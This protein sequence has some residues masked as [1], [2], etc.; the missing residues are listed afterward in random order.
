MAQIDGQSGLLDL[1]LIKHTTI[2]QPW[3]VLTKNTQNTVYTTQEVAEM[4]EFD[5]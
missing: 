1:P 5:Q 4:V 2:F 3:E